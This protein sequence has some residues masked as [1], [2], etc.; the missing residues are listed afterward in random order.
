MDLEM[1]KQSLNNVVGLF[2]TYIDMKKDTEKLK[3]HLDKN[4][5]KGTDKDRT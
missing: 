3:K 5:D 1:V 4:E 2:D